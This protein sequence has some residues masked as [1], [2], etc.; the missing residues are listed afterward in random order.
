MILKKIAK[1]DLMILI[2]DDI[3][4]G[5]FSPGTHLRLD[6]LAT[7]FEVS[8]MPIRE[9]LRALEAEG[10]VYSIPHRGS[11]VTE[12]TA[13][14]LLDI[15]EMRAA[16]EKMA[17]RDAVPR[18]T[19]NHL[20]QF[21]EMVNNWR[22]ES[23]DLA[24]MVQ[25]NNDFHKLIYQTAN[26]PHLYKEIMVLRNRTPHYLRSYAEEMGRFENA[27]QAHQALVDAFQVGNA[28]NAGNLMFKHIWDVGQALAEYIRS[29]DEG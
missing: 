28:E 9:A 23:D 16:L 19:E 29:K 10:I 21:Q 17:T 1:T 8:T 20:E 6:K 7:R 15:F 4:R 13:D 3:V 11:Y 2:R 26:R 14:E 22:A 25:Q 5:E 18:F 12:F 27:K 24:L